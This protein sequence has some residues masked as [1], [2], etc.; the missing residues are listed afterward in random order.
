MNY[1]TAKKIDATLQQAKFGS[2]DCY[3]CRVSDGCDDCICSKV[4]LPEDGPHVG[5]GFV[6]CGNI[7]INRGHFCDTYQKMIKPVTVAWTR[8]NVIDAIR[9]AI[10]REVEAAGR[11]K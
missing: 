4:E 5:L 10:G 1:W 3:L 7:M 6:P 9:W 8:E 2:L 11:L